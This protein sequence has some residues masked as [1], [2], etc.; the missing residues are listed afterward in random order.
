[1][2]LQRVH[3]TIIRRIK[4]FLQPSTTIHLNN[5]GPVVKSTEQFPLSSRKIPSVEASGI[6]FPFKI[7][8]VIRNAQVQTYKASVKLCFPILSKHRVMLSRS[9]CPRCLR[10]WSAAACW[11]CGFESGQGGWKSLTCECCVLLDRGLYFGLI[12]RPEE[13]YRVWCV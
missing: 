10:R 5:E 7:R 12:T 3:I 11:D 13:S 2:V 8:D 1:M 9:Q 4:T 6:S